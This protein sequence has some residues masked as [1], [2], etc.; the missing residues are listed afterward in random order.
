MDR[1]AVD[2]SFTGRDA[3]E[4]EPWHAFHGRGRPYAVPVDR[5]RLAQTVVTA[6]VRVSPSRQR[7]MGAVTWPLT[8]VP[9]AWRPLMVSG[10][11]PISSRNSVPLKTGARVGAARAVRS[12]H[13]TSESAPAAAA[14][15]MNRRR[16][17]M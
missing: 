4:T 1:E 6:S 3:A 9:V 8:P 15:W 16:V 17:R 12:G 7:K 13:G 5:A 10:T 14:L 11:A 2:K